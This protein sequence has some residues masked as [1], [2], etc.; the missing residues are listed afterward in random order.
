MLPPGRFRKAIS[1]GIFEGGGRKY[2]GEQDV[3]EATSLFLNRFA[4]TYKRLVG[5][6]LSWNTIILIGGGSALL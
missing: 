4:D 6:T 5:G 1:T 3:R 2:S